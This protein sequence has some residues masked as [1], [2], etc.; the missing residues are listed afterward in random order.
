MLM[1]DWMGGWV[2][3]LMYLCVGRWVGG[4]DAWIG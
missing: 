1:G 4:M 2:G 3:G